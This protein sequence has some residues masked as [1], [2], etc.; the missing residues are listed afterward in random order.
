MSYKCNLCDST[1]VEKRY[2]TRHIKAKTCQKKHICDK[3]NREFS[4]AQ[5]LRNHKN[6]K[7]PCVPDTVPVI[8]TANAHITCKFCGKKYANN[9]NLNR[10]QKNCVIKSDGR[11][12]MNL[13]DKIDQLQKQVS[14]N[15]QPTI[16]N[17]TINVD[18]S[19]NIYLNVTI[20][21]FGN[22]DLSKLDT[23]A[24]MK[25][26]KN[27]AEDFMPKM[28]EHV[29]ANPN[30]PEFHNVFYDPGREKA[31]VFA[32]IS[33]SEMSWQAHDLK[34]ISNQLTRKIKEHI[35]PGNGPY[36][37]MAMQNK[38]SKTGNNIAQIID[39][40]WDSEEVLSLTK[41]SLTKVTKNKGFQDIV[42]IS[43]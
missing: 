21:S 18:N 41:D 24:V 28:I 38:D 3:C 27:H 5:N 42:E 39:K 12:L 31:M 1:F 6:R 7:N 33:D 29:H 25:L 8:N 37:D 30:L 9:Y 20:C 43:E 26:L 2:F 13:M 14:T 22:E 32:P 34:D 15:H 4:T 40:K 35:R 23:A 36:F 17:N 16:I 11:I 19:K 10:H